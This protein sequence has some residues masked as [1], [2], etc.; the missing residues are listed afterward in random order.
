MN[1]LKQ[2]YGSTRR[3]HG[4]TYVF[5]GTTPHDQLGQAAAIR[6]EHIAEGRPCRVTTVGKRGVLDNSGKRRTNCNAIWVCY[7]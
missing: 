1:D 7:E 3:F 2:L 4:K 6:R 5:E